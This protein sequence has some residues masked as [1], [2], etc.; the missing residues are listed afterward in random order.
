MTLADPISVSL[1]YA[2]PATIDAVSRH[3]PGPLDL[4]PNNQGGMSSCGW[5]AGWVKKEEKNKLRREQ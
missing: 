1:I 3:F 4:T 5:L 2:A